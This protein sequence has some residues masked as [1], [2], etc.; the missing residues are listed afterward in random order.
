MLCNIFQYRNI[1]GQPLDGVQ[2]LFR[3]LA[4]GFMLVEV[5]RFGGQHTPVAVHCQIKVRI[6]PLDGTQQ[7]ADFDFGVQLFS[8]F[9]YQRLLRRFTQLYLPARKLLPAFELAISTLRGEYPIPSPD[10]CGNN[11][12]AFHYSSP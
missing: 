9:A 1:G 5:K 8:D 7:I 2:L 11:L 12:N 4:G 10:Y 3:E 6:V